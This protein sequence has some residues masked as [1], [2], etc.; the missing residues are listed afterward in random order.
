MKPPISCM[1]TGGIGGKYASALCQDGA[2]DFIKIDEKIIGGGVI[3]MV[4]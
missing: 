4:I 2:R 1:D 3:T